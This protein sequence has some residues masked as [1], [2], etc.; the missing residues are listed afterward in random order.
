MTKTSLIYIFLSTLLLASCITD[1]TQS[2]EG[3]RAGGGAANVEQVDTCEE[4]YDLSNGFTEAQCLPNNCN[5]FTHE[6][7]DEELE[8]EIAQLRTLNLEE[9]VLQDILANIDTAKAVCL[10]GSGVLRPDKEID[11]NSKTFCACKNGKPH[12]LT[13]C[14]AICASKQNAND[15]TLT[16]FGDA[17]LSANVDINFGSLSEWCRREI[18]QSSFRGPGCQLKIVSRDGSTRQI[19]VNIPNNS[20]N[21]FTAAIAEGLTM[22]YG[23]DYQISI[24]ESQSGSNAETNSVGIRLK[25]YV[26]PNDNTIVGNLLRVAVSKYSCL[27]RSAILNNGE[28]EYQAFAKQHYFF[29]E[30]SKP[31]PILPNRP[32]LKCHDGFDATNESREDD[33]ALYNR[34]ELDPVNMMMWDRN[35][36][37]LADADGVE[38]ID[39]NALITEEFKKRTNQQSNSAIN[40]ERFFEF[41]WQL[42]PNDS[43]DGSTTGAALES[44]LGIIMGPSVIENLGN[45]GKCP[46]QEDYLGNDIVFNIIGDFVGVDTEGIY[47]AESEPYVSSTTDPTSGQ[48]NEQRI[49]DILLVKESDLKASHF[50]ISGEKKFVPDENTI[51]TKTI[52]FYYPFSTNEPLLRKPH[53]RLYTIRYP[54]EIGGNSSGI[55]S[56]V[57]PSDKRFGCIPVSSNGSL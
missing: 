38:G 6:A 14:S 13:R 43:S 44:T 15:N 35:D 39:I 22:N 49:V 27:F 55:I 23:E 2:K 26:D 1:A 31:A 51:G 42:R 24:I 33:N 9:D 45:R 12:V 3:F 10:E 46:K 54:D 48:T 17:L 11:I 30:Q 19:D 41:K 25:E 56:G 34:L 50:Y 29:V 37:R 36:P 18:P 16:L 21:T 47:M 4:Y 28:I 32:L 40:I 7:T 8:Q 5:S 52:H 57:R 53:Q 20:T